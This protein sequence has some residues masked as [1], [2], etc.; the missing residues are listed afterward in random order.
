M[1]SFTDYKTIN[2]SAQFLGLIAGGVWTFIFALFMGS[3]KFPGVQLLAL[4]MFFYTPWM[5]FK[6]HRTHRDMRQHGVIS[7][8]HGML[9]LSHVVFYASLLLAAATFV[10][11]QFIDNGLLITTL[12]TNLSQPG[13]DET[14]RAMGITPE[15]MNEQ[16]NII[17][18]S[19]PIDLAISFATNAFLS[20]LCLAVIISLI[21]RRSKAS[22]H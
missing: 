9:F 11:F 19:R 14:L 17:S 6:M 22:N 4:L 21:G 1:I 8:G 3:L 20:S 2:H 10:Y 12:T 5:L 15:Q 18:Q 13:M 16:V 7:F